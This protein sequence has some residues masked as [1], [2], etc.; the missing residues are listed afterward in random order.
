MKAYENIQHA[1]HNFSCKYNFIYLDFDFKRNGIFYCGDEDSTAPLPSP[2]SVK[3][4]IS[5]AITQDF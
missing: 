1:F 3:T 5:L 4:C 2:P